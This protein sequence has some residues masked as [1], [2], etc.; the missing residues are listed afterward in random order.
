MARVAELDPQRGYFA[1]DLLTY[2]ADPAD[3]G[4]PRAQ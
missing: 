3:L 4:H 2:E 1:H